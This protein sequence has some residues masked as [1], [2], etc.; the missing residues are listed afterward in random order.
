MNEPNDAQAPPALRR[1]WLISIGTELTLGQSVD[2]NAAW[3][4]E[5]LAG[6]GIRAERHVTVADDLSAIRDTLT[7]AAQAADLIIVTGGLGPTEDD[8]TRQALADAAGVELQSDPACLAQIRAFF[9]R[10]RRKFTEHNSVQALVP[11]TG[12]AIENHCGTAPGIFIEIE[13]T[14]CHALPGV[15]FE[16]KEMFTR[17]VLPHVRAAAAGRIIRSRRLNCFGPGESDIG[18]QLRDLMTPGHNPQVG[19]TAELGIIGVRLNAEAETANAAETLLDHAEAE[20]RAR[21]GKVVFGRNADT[22]ASVVG[23]RL[24]A[25]GETL[26]T[27]ESCTGGL[28]AKLLT[29]TPGSSDYFVGGAVTYSNE[30]KQQA[31]GVSAGMLDEFGAVSEPVARAMAI[32]ARERFA[33]TFALA[34]TGIAGPDG[35]TPDKPVGLVHFGLAGPDGVTTRELRLGSDAPRH[36]IRARAARCALNL[37]RL[38][39]VD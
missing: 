5:Q 19:T 12:R 16:M 36:V 6:L 22:L 24:V 1:A 17:A 21:L 35:R 30:L 3:L 8:L 25:R 13:G 26:C 37:L 14:P 4:A 15:P 23:A 2:T 20:V 29:D 9:E 27:A 28:I 32:G 10:R 7:Q 18:E 38:A 33:A 31:L 39:L 34:V 11:R